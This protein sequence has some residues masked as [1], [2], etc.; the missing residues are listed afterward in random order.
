MQVNPA[1]KISHES[2]NYCSLQIC[3]LFE[4]PCRE[5]AHSSIPQHGGHAEGG[6]RWVIATVCLQQILPIFVRFNQRVLVPSSGRYNRL[7][8]GT[9][10]G[11]CKGCVAITCLLQKWHWYCLRLRPP[12]FHTFPN[13]TN[14]QDQWQIQGANW[15]GS[16]HSSKFG[17]ILITPI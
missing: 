17:S 11:A 7:Q 4:P 1:P 10:T 8:R 16:M 2:V 12:G 14:G 9:T 6:C 3:L 15:N 13:C 5:E